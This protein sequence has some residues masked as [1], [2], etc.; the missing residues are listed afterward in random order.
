MRFSHEMLALGK[1]SKNKVKILDFFDRMLYNG[2]NQGSALTV[3]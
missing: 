1:Q 3:L 2:N